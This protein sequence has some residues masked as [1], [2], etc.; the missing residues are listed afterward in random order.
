MNQFVPAHGRSVS[1]N[2]CDF[3]AMMSCGFILFVSAST[4]VSDIPEKILDA[5]K[6]NFDTPKKITDTPKD[7]ADVH[8]NM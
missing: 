4:R 5:S 7:I 1:A 8:C 2:P 3:G 6:K